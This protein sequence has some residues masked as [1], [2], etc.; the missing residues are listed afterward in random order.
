MIKFQHGLDPALQNQVALLG[1]GAPDF[2]DLEGWYEA[3]W[4]VFQIKEANKPFV[5]MNRGV[6]C[7]HVP[8][9][10]ATKFGGVFVLTRKVFPTAPMQSPI[11]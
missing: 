6:T 4:R 9:P 2:G 10:P 11:P 3:A 7:S 1:N 5:E 8:T